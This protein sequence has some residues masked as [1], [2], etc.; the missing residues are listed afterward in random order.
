MKERTRLLNANGL[1]FARLLSDL[2]FASRL[3]DILTKFGMDAR[4]SRL[5]APERILSVISLV[6]SDCDLLN[7]A[8][9]QLHTLNLKQTIKNQTVDSIIRKIYDHL[10]EPNNISEAGGFVAA[11]KTMHFILPELFIMLDGQHIAISLYNISDYHPH[12]NDGGGWSTVVSNY[13]G[14]EPPNPSPRGAGRYSWDN[15]RYVVALMYYKRIIREWCQ[16][17]NADVK[18]FLNLDT[19]NASTTS[20]IIDS[21]KV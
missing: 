13:S 12:P 3:R 20:R 5:M 8:Q 14:R 16:Q 19:Q 10:A 6:G 4:A 11:S 18:S 7:M 1:N 9:I 21:Q 17:N 2:S 15:K